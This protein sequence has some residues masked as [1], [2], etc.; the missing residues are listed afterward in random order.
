MLQNSLCDHI[1][2]VRVRNQKKNI[3][4]IES[5]NT[6]VCNKL[7]KFY[8]NADLISIKVKWPH[9]VKFKRFKFNMLVVNFFKFSIFLFWHHKPIE[10]HRNFA[11]RFLK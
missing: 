1:F 3:K 6:I 7:T 4:Y 5:D 9:G 11:P 10:L 8:S 2:V